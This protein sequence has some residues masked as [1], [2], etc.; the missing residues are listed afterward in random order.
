MKK[1]AGAAMAALTI[2]GCAA[3]ARQPADL[4]WLSGYWVK[5]AD[6]QQVS[7]TWGSMRDGMMVGMN[8]TS[9]GDGPA[10]EFLRIAPIGGDGDNKD[11][12]AYFAQ[13]GG[14][15]ATV[16][17]LTPAESG[18]AKAVFENVAHDFPQR[19]IY[20]R[21]GATLSVRIEGMMGGKLEGMEWSF[22]SAPLNQACPG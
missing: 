13:P 20:S 8:Q 12:L 14:Q 10:W 17:A 21:D 1:L 7:E 16:F 19:I 3:D 11:V 15:P 9:G 6:G 22:T 18:A 4:S 5:C 2:G